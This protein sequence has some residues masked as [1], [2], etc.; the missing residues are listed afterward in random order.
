LG[1]VAQRADFREQTLTDK[2]IRGG[3]NRVRPFIAEDSG[4]TLKR[5][6]RVKFGGFHMRRAEKRALRH[7][8]R[9]ERR[10]DR[11]KRDIA[12]PQP[13]SRVRPRGYPPISARQ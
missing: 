3:I 13:R 1:L 10:S 8:K 7:E 6:G 9:E 5:A 4:E 11:N 12:S 2:I